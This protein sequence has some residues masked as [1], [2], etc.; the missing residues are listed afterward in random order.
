MSTAHAA[1]Q[2]TQG[3]AGELNATSCG[4]NLLRGVHLGDATIFTL[5]AS[6]GHR[7]A[8]GVVAQA[9]HTA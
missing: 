6:P 2:A 4:S 8:A 3:M 5:D 1:M 7:V 9:S